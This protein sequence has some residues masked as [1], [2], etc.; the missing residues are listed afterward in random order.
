[1]E[2]R[3]EGLSELAV[4]LDCVAG[5]LPALP[6]VLATET[7]VRTALFVDGRLAGIISIG[8]VVRYRVDELEGLTKDL[9][10]YV[11]GT[12]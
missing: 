2:L 12:W 3:G 9:E 6:D 1:M 5:V 7:I 8:D 11:S 10:S 4:F